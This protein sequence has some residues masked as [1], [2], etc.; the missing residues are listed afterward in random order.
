MRCGNL[1]ENCPSQPKLDKAKNL[2]QRHKDAK[3]SR[4]ETVQGSEVWG[5]KV[6]HVGNGLRLMSR[7]G[8]PDFIHWVKGRYKTVEDGTPFMRTGW[9]LFNPER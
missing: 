1:V 6:T 2:P 3:Q 4:L 7:S 5:S 9:M 8:R